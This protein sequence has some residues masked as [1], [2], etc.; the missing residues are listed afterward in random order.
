MFS[1][2]KPGT[3]KVVLFLFGQ[4]SALIYKSNNEHLGTGRVVLSKIAVSLFFIF[5]TSII[6]NINLFTL[7]ALFTTCSRN[8]VVLRIN[9]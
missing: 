6:M 8:R 2:N 1:N 5:E 7:F 4:D 9:V 3:K